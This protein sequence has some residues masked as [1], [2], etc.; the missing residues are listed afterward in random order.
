MNILTHS[1]SC[2]SQQNTQHPSENQPIPQTPKKIF[3]HSLAMICDHQKHEKYPT[4][5]HRFA[6]ACN[7]MCIQ[8]A[9]I[10]RHARTSKEWASPSLLCSAM[11][12]R[13]TQIQNVSKVSLKTLRKISLF[14]IHKHR[15]STH[16][17]HKNISRAVEHKAYMEFSHKKNKVKDILISQHTTNGEM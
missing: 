16:M 1:P 3:A 17:H 15:Y 4:P 5:T 12:A 7:I 11:A 8:A 2:T 6:S 13:A 14:L 9:L 10:K